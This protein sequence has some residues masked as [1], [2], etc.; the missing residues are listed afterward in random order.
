MICSKI[1]SLFHIKSSSS[2][3]EPTPTADEMSYV[4]KK[5]VLDQAASADKLTLRVLVENILLSQLAVWSSGV[6]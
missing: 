6:F 1:V 4:Q 2:T 3:K 5:L